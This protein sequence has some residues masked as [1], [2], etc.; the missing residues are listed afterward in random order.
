MGDYQKLSLV[1]H[2]EWEKD[3]DFLKLISIHV[4]LVDKK[5]QMVTGSQDNHEIPTLNWIIG[6]I[7]SSL[8]LDFTRDFIFIVF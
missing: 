5:I 8:Q 2:V 3:G 1:F 4:S 7:N 6:T